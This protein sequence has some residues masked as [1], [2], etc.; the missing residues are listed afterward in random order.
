[1]KYISLPR[2]LLICLVLFLVD[3]VVAA[4]V[5]RGPYLQQASDTSIVV[6]WRTD[7]VSS[8]RVRYGISAGA[9]SSDKSSVTAVKDHEL[10]LTGLSEGQRYYYDIGSTSTVLAGDATYTFRTATTANNSTVRVWVLGDAGTKNDDQRAVRDAF[11][12]WNKSVATDL[13]LLL[14]DN[15]Y[16]KGTDSEYQAAIFDMYPQSLR[17]AVFW[18]TIGNHDTD[19]DDDPALTIP[20]FKIFTNPINAESGGVASGTEKYYSFNHGPIH[21]VCLDSMTSSRV[22]N[23]AMATWA[24]AD[25]SANT[26]PWTVAFWHHPPYSKGSHDSDTS[27]HLREMRENLL[28]I[29]EQQG[30]DLVLSGHSHSYERSYFIDGHYGLSS[31][32]NESHKKQLGNGASGSGYNK[33]NESR[34]GAVFAVPGSAGKTSGGSLNHPAMVSSLNELGSFCFEV[35]HNRLQAWMI[36]SDGEVRDTFTIT[37]STVAPP[38]PAAPGVTNGTTSTPTISGTTTAGATMHIYSD[39]ALIGT[40]VANGSGAWTYTVSPPLTPGTHVITV[41]TTPIGGLTSGF[42]PGTTI[43]VNDSGGGSSSPT[44]SSSSGGGL[45]GM[46]SGVAGLLLLLSCFSWLRLHQ[47]DD[48]KSKSRSVK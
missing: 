34:G 29:L 38:P 6:R 36:R 43:T 8:S 13:V 35:S 9:L 45:C 26:K 20:Y 4:T 25:L 12:G 2:V 40:V 14:G 47:K 46:G 39:G 1:M 24:A 7:V 5:T 37:K 10:T 31:T 16:S 32:F 18:S 28:P 48:Q 42:S 23:G 21:F 15:A 33:S 19:L 22:K 3:D 27:T 41:T 17:Q 30:V 44:T 11:Y